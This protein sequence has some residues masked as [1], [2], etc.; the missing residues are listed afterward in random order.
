MERDGLRDERDKK[1]RRVM[2]TAA[3]GEIGS[4]VHVRDNIASTA[5]SIRIE[6]RFDRPRPRIASQGKHQSWAVV[7]AVSE[8]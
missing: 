1:S 3:C 5:S 6:N 2:T 8:E 7:I 4:R